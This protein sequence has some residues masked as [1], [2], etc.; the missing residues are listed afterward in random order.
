MSMTSREVQRSNLT[1]NCSVPGSATFI[2]PSN[3]LSSG[4]SFISALRDKYTAST[5]P[6]GSLDDDSDVRI[7]PNTTFSRDI[8]V[9]GMDKIGKKFADTTRIR[10]VGLED[11]GISR[12]SDGE[13]LAEEL[14]GFKSACF[15]LEIDGAY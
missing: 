14:E 9:V 1:P 8:E 10:E 15:L 7:I 12:A 6:G 5:E 4:T 2:R 11:Q 13:D 3:R